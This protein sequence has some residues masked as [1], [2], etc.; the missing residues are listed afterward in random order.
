M[1]IAGPGSRQGVAEVRLWLIHTYGMHLADWRY[2]KEYLEGSTP[3]IRSVL[4]MAVGCEGQQ[5]L[6]KT[7]RTSVGEQLDTF[8][9]F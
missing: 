3:W 9:H 7:S 5:E 6:H 1:A 2:G 8:I 4:G